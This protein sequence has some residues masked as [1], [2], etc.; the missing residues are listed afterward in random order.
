M[1][2][3]IKPQ[4]GLDALEPYEPDEPIEELQRAYGFEEMIELALNENPLGTSPKALAAIRQ[5]KLEANSH[6]GGYVGR[7]VEYVPKRLDRARK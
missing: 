5:A 4:R 3:H 1:T 6:V 2:T 7:M